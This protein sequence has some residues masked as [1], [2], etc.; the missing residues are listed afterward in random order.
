MQWNQIEMVCQ[1]LRRVE[2]PDELNELKDL[3]ETRQEHKNAFLFFFSIVL[4]GVLFLNDITD[5]D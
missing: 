2:V 3:V 5:E 1:P 4:E